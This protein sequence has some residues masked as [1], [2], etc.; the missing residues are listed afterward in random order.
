MRILDRARIKYIK[1]GAFTGGW[2][3]LCGIAEMISGLIYAISNGR[4]VTNWVFDFHTW[5]IDHD[6]YNNP[7]TEMN[8]ENS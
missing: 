7:A 8:D 4:I 2:A 3:I 5:L 6:K 1:G